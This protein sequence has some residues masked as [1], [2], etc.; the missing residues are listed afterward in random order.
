MF[1][2]EHYPVTNIKVKVYNLKNAQQI[3]KTVYTE[4]KNEESVDL[5]C[6]FLMEAATSKGNQERLLRICGEYVVCE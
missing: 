6:E 3:L 5:A 2:E 1:K 4:L